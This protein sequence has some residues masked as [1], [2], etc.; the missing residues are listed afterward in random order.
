MVQELFD[1]V[2]I[3]GID[4]AGNAV[5]EAEVPHLDEFFA[6]GAVTFKAKAPYPTISAECWGALL[7]GVGP[8]KH[9][10]TNEIVASR[11]YPED[12]SY[13]SFMKLARQKW[14]Q[15]ILASFCCWNP[16]NHGI[17]EVSC[18]SWQ[19]SAPDEELVESLL[20][21]IARND[22][23]QLFVHL[24]AVDGAGHK[25]GYRTGPY[26][27]QISRTDQL[28]GRILTAVA[29]LEGKTLSIICADHGGGGANPK[30]H[31]SAHPLDSEVFWSCA[32]PGIQA[33]KIR[34]EFLLQD[35][36]AV[37]AWAQG[38]AVPPAWE[39]KLPPELA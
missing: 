12:S 9:G 11:P 10:L 8:E 27:A 18:A 2:L 34:S 23:R 13:P 30:S 37:V 32:G 16:I 28:V 20:G 15:D 31:G 3:I 35:T 19:E 26:Y 21:F 39:S 33:Q 4:G 29:A 22:F 38:L 17:I 6:R 7:H 36:A 5:Q 25:H 1:R 14:P 24:D